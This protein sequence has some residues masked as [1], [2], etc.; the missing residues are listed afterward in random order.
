MIWAMTWH[1]LMTQTGLDD[2]L[3]LGL[4][5]AVAGLLVHRAG[6]GR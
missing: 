3:A 2:T 1:E 5:C 4:V 6:R